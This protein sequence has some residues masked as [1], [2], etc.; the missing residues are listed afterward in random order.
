MAIAAISRAGEL[1]YMQPGG[2]I[3]VPS[4]LPHTQKDNS[5]GETNDAA[6]DTRKGKGGC[7]RRRRGP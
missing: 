2:Y 6:S 7:T 1:Q 5:L 3:G 4:I